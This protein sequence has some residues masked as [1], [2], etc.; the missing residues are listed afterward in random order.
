MKATI[1]SIL[2]A[3]LATTSVAQE[4]STAQFNEDTLR[5]S[6]APSAVSMSVLRGRKA[7]LR[8][9]QI[10]DGVFDINRFTSTGPIPCVDGKAGEYSCNKVDLKGFLAHK[11]TGSATR[12]GNDVW[13]TFSSS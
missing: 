8:E 2:F 5:A 9:Q 12:E 13:G 4:M 10:A 7:A 1:A 11:D 3:A 6:N